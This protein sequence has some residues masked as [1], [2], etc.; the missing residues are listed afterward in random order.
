MLLCTQISQCGHQSIGSPSNLDDNSRSLLSL[1]LNDFANN[2]LHPPLHRNRIQL[3]SPNRQSES[4]PNVLSN[5]QITIDELAI[6]H[7][8]PHQAPCRCS[9]ASAQNLLHHQAIPSVRHGRPKHVHQ[10]GLEA[11]DVHLERPRCRRCHLRGCPEQT[12]PRRRQPVRA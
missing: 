6:V 12:S 8:T 11:L 3:C 2:L 10:H 5:V 4:P 1:A 9:F 7:T